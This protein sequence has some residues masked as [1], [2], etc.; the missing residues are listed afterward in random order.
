LRYISVFLV[1]VFSSVGLSLEDPVSTNPLGLGTVPPTAYESGLIPSINP[2]DTRG[3]LIITGNV[4]GGMHFRGVVPYGGATDFIAPA[5][6]LQHTS[7]AFDSFLRRSA[8]S[9][10]FESYGGG[11]TPYYSPTLTATKLTPSG[12]TVIPPQTVR[13]YG[14]DLSLDSD[15]RREQEDYYNKR[16]VPIASK[17]PLSMGQGDLEE[18]LELDTSKFPQGVEPVSQAQSQEQFWQELG[19]TIERRPVPAVD[20]REDVLPLGMTAG[21][22]TDVAALLGTPTGLSPRSRAGQTEQ[23]DSAVLEPKVQQ[24]G[25][26]L[27]ASRNLDTYELMKIRLG[28][29]TGDVEGLG[30]ELVTGQ[31]DANVPAFRPA[32]SSAGPAD[33]LERILSGPALPEVAKT[34]VSTIGTAGAG[35]PYKSFAAFTNDKFN[36]YMSS[37]ESYMKQGRF[38]RAADAYTLAAL[39]KPGAPLANAGKSHALFAAGEFLSSS[40]FLARAVEIFP[41]YVKLRVDLVAMIGDKDKVEKRI[42]EA[43]E[44]FDKS[45]SAELGFLLGYVYYQMDRLEFARM[46]I[47]RA[48]E[49]MPESEAIAVMKKAIQERIANL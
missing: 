6:S 47:E 29:L 20:T 23:I 33:A 2:I 22:E 18:V 19:I 10:Y 41:E 13:S 39:V 46:V 25:S 8:G 30:E 34:N 24:P 9:Q 35:D 7:G 37:A 16:R 3:N 40:L 38:Y 27:E 15:L 5:S 11:V 48:A 31:L 32:T 28:K 1:I 26:V 12:V 49:K 17:R 44:W 14:V 4:T 45:D 42:L 36:Q 43:R 21:A